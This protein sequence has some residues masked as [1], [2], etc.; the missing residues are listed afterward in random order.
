M[1]S[2]PSLA[3]S[4]A[5]YKSLFD[6]M[7]DGLAYGK[8]VFDAQ[9]KPI[10]YIYIKVNKRFGELTGLKK[11]VG[12]KVTEI[13]PG[14]A[15][16]NPDWIEAH[17]RVALTGKPERFEVYLEQIHRWFFVSLYSTEKNF[18]VSIFQNITLQKQE[19]KKLEDAKVAAQNVLEDLSVE[20]VKYEE[21]AKD[22]EKF[23]LATD[24]AADNIVITDP[25]GI[26]IYANKSLE[27]ITGYT[28]EEAL[29]KKSGV[30]WKSPM[31]LG[32]YQNMWDI[33]KN[34]KKI[35]IGEIQNKRKN[36]LIYTASISISPILDKNGEIKFFVGIERDITK[37]KEVE[38][39]KD[40]FM[41]LASH[42]LRTPPSIISWYTET[43]QSGEL[44]PTNEKQTAYLAE[45]Y[46]ANQRM[47]AVI[48]S[49]LNISRIEMGTFSIAPK[50][51]DIRE[52]IDETIKELESRFDRK[53]EI[54]KDYDARLGPFKMDQNI[55]QIII[56]NLLSNSFKY[57]PPENTKIEIAIKIENDFLLLSVK[58]NGIGI[59]LKDRGR[60]FEKLFRSD[61]AVSANPDGTGLGLYMIKRMIVDGLGGKIWFDSEEDKGSTFYVSLPSSG[62]KEKPGTTTLAR[63]GTVAS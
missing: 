37:E 9:K 49:L 32:Y 36:G 24:N 47:I 58:D 33:I 29:G 40:E 12:K 31:P 21:Q 19:E 10:D 14:V 22:L 20:E 54:K 39:A 41:S 16:S 1:A 18:F 50:E 17:S 46:K 61:N 43:L 53:A 28:P 25:E 30:L 7:L 23:K 11:V 2:K 42:Q 26:V 45:I 57:S 34:Q 8:I 63:V 59:P 44:G 5:L 48:N 55:I 51:I 52:V 6:N 4:S 56:D 27:A 35:F 62:M 3:A 15:A 60:V 38:R 13:I